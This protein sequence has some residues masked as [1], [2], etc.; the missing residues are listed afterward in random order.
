ML[1]HMTCPS[2][3]QS[4]FSMATGSVF[5]PEGKEKK[6]W[7]CAFQTSWLKL[8]GVCSPPDKKVSLLRLLLPTSSLCLIPSS[9]WVRSLLCLEIVSRI[10]L[11]IAGNTIDLC[12]QDTYLLEKASV[13]HIERQQ[14]SLT[15]L[16][17]LRSGPWHLLQNMLH[18]FKDEASLLAS[19]V[20]MGRW[21]GH[22]A[23][24]KL[25]R[26]HGHA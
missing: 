20:R 16:C 6:L 23:P 7:F 25:R 15:H 5:F 24:E 11:Q 9:S 18:L 3:S 13:A 22:G 21:N 2:W 19:G 17:T 1:T 26:R 4:C 8:K 14:L 10:R 12:T